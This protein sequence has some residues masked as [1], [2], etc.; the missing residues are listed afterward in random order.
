MG[1]QK[2][3]GP[4]P[5]SGGFSIKVTSFVDLFVKNKSHV[6][7]K[8]TLIFLLLSFYSRNVAFIVSVVE[9]TIL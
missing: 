4:G 9:K 7:K 5:G 3:G 2:S 8:A 6:E 1:S